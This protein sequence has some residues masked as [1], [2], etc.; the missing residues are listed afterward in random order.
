MHFFNFYHHKKDLVQTFSPLHDEDPLLSYEVTN[1]EYHHQLNKRL[2]NLELKE[3]KNSKEYLY[4]LATFLT[5][6]DFNNN[7]TAKLKE[8]CN[9]DIE[10][11]NSDIHHIC[12]EPQL[13]CTS[14]NT[15]ISNAIKKTKDDL[16][17]ETNYHHCSRLQTECFFLEQYGSGDLSANCNKLKE[18]CYN[19]ARMEVAEGIMHRFLKGTHDKTCLEKLKEKCLL[20]SHQSPE[21]FSLCISGSNVCKKFISETKTNCQ[22]FQTQ[23][24]SKHKEI[25]R[26][27]CIV[28]LKKCYY[29][30]L[31]CQN[32]YHMCRLFQTSCA[33][34]GFFSNFDSNYNLNLLESPFIDVDEDTIQYSHKKLSQLGIYVDKMPSL[35]NEVIASILIQDVSKQISKCKKELNEKCPLVEYLDVFKDICSKTKNKDNICK[36]IYDKTK[37]HLEPYSKEFSGNNLSISQKSFSKEKCIEYLPL[38]YFFNEYFGVWV[39]SDLCKTIRLA[40]YQADLEMEADMILI[41]KL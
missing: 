1:E 26:E 32:I 22:N 41:R 25:T 33:E 6:S 38:C 13:V 11:L 36:G 2:H 14:L 39:Q 20:F 23:F 19:K 17:K 40:C 34:K 37:Q 24:L 16:N 31:N 3:L 8:V 21:L 4:Y 12:N 5:F 27:N 7:C 28:W 29:N 18:N 35:P 10:M 9:D 30:V 15:Q